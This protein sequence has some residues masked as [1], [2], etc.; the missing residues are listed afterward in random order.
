MFVLTMWVAGCVHVSAPVTP[1]SSAHV[2]PEIGDKLAAADRL[3]QAGCY[4]CLRDALVTYE[5]L[6]GDAS[7][8]PNAR[9]SAVRTAL[10]LALRETE[11]GLVHGGFIERARQLLGPVE[12]ASPELPA[13]VDIAEVIAS[14]PTG[15]TRSATTDGQFAA[16]LTVARKQEQWASVLRN[17]MPR[18][19]IATYLWVGLACGP[20]GSNFP[21]HERRD[22]VIEAVADVPLISYKVATGCGLTSSE[23][24]EAQLTKV[25]SFGEI[26][27]H[28][29]L[30]ALGG[31]T[32]HLPD[33]DAADTRFLAAYEWRQDW[34]TLTLA[35]GNVAMSA[36]D[37]PRA[38]AFFDRTLGLSPDDTEAMV[39]AV[40][41]LTYAGRHADAITAADRLI[42]TGRNPGD[43]H[44]WRAMNLARLKQDDH[45]WTDIEE[46]A[47]SLVNADV[48]KLA[49]IIAITRR[50]MAVA[51]DRLGLAL[52]RRPS[53]CETGYYLQ[54]VLAEQ[55]DWNAT[56]RVASDAGACFDSEEAMVQ[57][58][59]ATVRA[60]VMAPDRR[61][62]LI[63]RREQQLVTAARMKATVW[64]NAAAAN[65]NLSRSADARVFAE[66]VVDDAFYGE[67]ART[68]L[69]RLK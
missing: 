18:D 19:L 14:G 24:L 50:D 29:G 13:L 63:A 25:P 32:A 9:D 60:A 23:V 17:L 5:G 27:Y 56:A 22:V 65:F 16:M 45:A 7:V 67:R 47:R 21:D 37:F 51:R 64:F 69:E 49:G 34:P 39:G 52:S 58:E 26:N 2:A 28:L 4:D 53:D 54:S 1:Q 42:A 59:L 68:L 33:L 66:K 38:L 3:V 11:I 61:D 10:L 30:F 41:A 20:Y 48:P 40:R 57:Q 46:A 35:I 12:I 6:Q 31:Q 62:R 8:G 15:F 43:A 36:E 44:Y 55:R